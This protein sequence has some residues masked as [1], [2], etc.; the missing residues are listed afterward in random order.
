MHENLLGQN[1]PGEPPHQ[2]K[3]EANAQSPER[4]ARF[5]RYTS[6][7][8]S[9]AVCETVHQEKGEATSTAQSVLHVSKSCLANQ[10]S[11]IL[12][13]V[14]V[15]DERFDLTNPH[16]WLNSVVSRHSRRAKTAGLLRAI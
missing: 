13:D 5:R 3:A 9:F 16:G 12:S 10:F 7:F 15:Q 1:N 2:A 11:G 14:R 8:D 4:C 6:K